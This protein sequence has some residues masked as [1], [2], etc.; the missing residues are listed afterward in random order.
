MIVT[1]KKWVGKSKEI[2]RGFRMDGFLAQNLS[3]IP[4]RLKEDW[5]VIAIV[6][7][8]DKVRIAKCLGKETKVKI[9]EEGKI[10]DSESLECYNDGEIL[11]TVSLI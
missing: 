3:R 5:D 4:G 6:S 1:D 10:R 2:R 11:K 8:R 9:F 7:G